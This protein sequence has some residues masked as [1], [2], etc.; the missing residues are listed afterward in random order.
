MSRIERVEGFTLTSP[1]DPPRAFSAGVQTSF[2]HIVVRITDSDGV[3]GYGECVPIPGA[4][5]ALEALG[6]ALLGEDP[7]YRER[8][9]GR[10]QRWWSNA[11]AVS[12]IS[13]ALDDLVARRL[14]IP[15][16]QL[17]GGAYRDRVRPYAASYGSI[18]G[19]QGESWIEEANALY[20]RGFRAMKLRLGA[21]PAG[22]EAANAEALRTQIPPDM[23]LLGDGNG[24]FGPTNAREMGHALE[25]L[26]F[27]WFEE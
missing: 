4:N 27:V 3:R 8:H 9:V 1:I 14:G 5:G 12:A 19:R 16:H 2:N 6:Q 11:F 20:E 13:I 18:V 21:E 15:V 24:G 10:M 7:M 23:D 26:G 17:Y 22:V 25:E